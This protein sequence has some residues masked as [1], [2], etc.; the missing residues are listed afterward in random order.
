MLFEI[1]AVKSQRL[2]LKTENSTKIK[3]I[4]ITRSTFTL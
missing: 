2:T 3:K 4:H 1:T